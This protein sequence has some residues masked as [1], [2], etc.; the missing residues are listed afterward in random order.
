MKRFLNNH[1]LMSGFYKGISGLSLFLSIRLLIDYLGNESYGVWVLVFTFFQ[2]VLLM[3]FGIQSAL[4]TQIPR[5]VFNE[6]RQS[7][8]EYIESNFRIS[9]VIAIFFFSILSLIIYFNNLKSLFNINNLTENEVDILFLINILFFCLTF[10]ANIHK[11]LFVAFLRGKYSEQSIAVNQFLFFIIFWIIIK[12]DCFDFSSF[13]KLLLVTLTNGV[14][15]LLINLA[16]TKFFFDSEK[17]PFKLFRLKNDLNIFKNM[18]G[19]GIKF[20]IIQVG[21]LF[22]FSSDNYIISNI[23]NPKSI[24]G[25]EVVNKLFQFPFMIIFAAL[26][27]IWSMFTKHYLEKNKTLLFNHF[28]RFNINFIFISLAIII[29]SLLTPFI[30]S[31]WIKDK[32]FIPDYL[33]LLTTLVT[34]FKIFVS[35]YTFFL[36]GIGRLNFYL[37]IL[38]ISVVVKI[39]LSFIFVKN[40]FGINSVLLSSLI[41]VFTWSI[42]IPIKCYKITH[43]IN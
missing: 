2:L 5:L 14:V 7:I 35:F 38:L 43:E 32:V 1:I 37:V 30:I 3:D 8:A 31:I 42:L 21:F 4:K 34:L 20:M 25:Y 23:F 15:C 40:G 24:V 9:I 10:V 12:S 27:P 33:I 41:I 22:I 6:N 29:L 28:R 13:Q 18:I 26:S 17:I 36:N 11:S 16:Y 19:L 39:P